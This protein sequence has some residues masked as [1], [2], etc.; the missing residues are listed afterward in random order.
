V[1]DLGLPQQ[2]P[3]QKRGV[4]V[5]EYSDVMYVCVNSTFK[6]G[7][8]MEDL[9]ECASGGGWVAGSD[10]D[11]WAVTAEY[12]AGCTTVVAVYYGYLLG[13]WTF[14]SAE[15]SKTGRYSRGQGRTN[16]RTRLELGEAVPVYFDEAPS[17]R[18]GVGRAAA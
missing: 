1:L 17:L 13:A 16:R 7:M 12:A 2:A 8:T 14:E 9:R 4:L 18:R 15:P 6:P 10:Q 3:T 5:G 11:G